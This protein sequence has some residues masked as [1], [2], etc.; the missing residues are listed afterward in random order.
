MTAAEAEEQTELQVLHDRAAATAREVTGTVTAL[1]DK[2]TQAASPHRW[3]RRKAANAAARTRRKAADAAAMARRAARRAPALP[4]R[5]GRPGLA[6]TVGLFAL[7]AVA[8][9]WQH[10]RNA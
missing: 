5:V 4:A 10:R 7:V 6:L 8:V 2:L 3:A 9:T 1:A